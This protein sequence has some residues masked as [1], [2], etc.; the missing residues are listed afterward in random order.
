MNRTKEKRT[1][2]IDE[3]LKENPFKF[4]ETCPKRKTTSPQ[5]KKRTKRNIDSKE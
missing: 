5:G 4:E 1:N 2:K 3:T